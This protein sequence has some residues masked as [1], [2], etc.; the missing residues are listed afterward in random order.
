MVLPTQS[1][2]RATSNMKTTAT[3][4]TAQAKQSCLSTDQDNIP[5][6]LTF[7]SKTSVIPSNQPLLPSIR[8]RESL[9]L[10]TTTTT[11]SDNNTGNTKTTTV[12]VSRTARLSSSSFDTKSEFIDS[13]PTA[14]KDNQTIHREDESDKKVTTETGASK[15]SSPGHHPLQLDFSSLPNTSEDTLKKVDDDTQDNSCKMTPSSSRLESRNSTENTPTSFRRI[16]S[17]GF[18]E[19]EKEG[20]S[21]E[22]PFRDLNDF[23]LSVDDDP[24]V[25]KESM[26]IERDR[27]STNNRRESQGN[28]GCCSTKASFSVNIEEG[29]RTTTELLNNQD[30]VQADPWSE[31][32]ASFQA[33]HSL[34]NID[35]TGFIPKKSHETNHS[36][37]SFKKRASTLG[38]PSIITTKPEVDVTTN[39][40]MTVAQQVDIMLDQYIEIESNKRMMQ[41]NVNWF[42]LTFKI[43]P[44]EEKF[45]QIKDNVF[46]SNA[47]CLAVSWFLVTL[48]EV[49]ILPLTFDSSLNYEAFVILLGSFLMIL[50]CL[51]VIMASEFYSIPLFVKK[52]SVFLENNRSSRHLV[53]CVYILIVFLSSI[54]VLVSSLKYYDNETLLITNIM[55][56]LILFLH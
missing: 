15:T 5:H 8:E 25:V 29:G 28:E 16:V 54:S 2:Y 56:L 35:L 26:N 9:S 24:V 50:M 55:S 3:S 48:S 45:H 49:V 32:R 52:A 23:R 51:F 6:H 19:E 53:A 17:L 38:G 34:V 42:C 37:I 10:T 27:L 12:T 44:M 47:V 22:I 40:G 36:M 13:D 18:I 46:K 14:V 4:T 41:Q 21:P 30:F 20:W 1:S 11:N 39:V 31:A 43:K 7:I 33:R